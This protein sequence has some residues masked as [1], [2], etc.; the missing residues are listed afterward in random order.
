MSGKSI[1]ILVIGI[2]LGGLG[3]LILTQP[4][5]FR[6]QSW[7]FHTG[8][9]GP[10]SPAVAAVVL[11]LVPPPITL[12]PPR[13]DDEDIASS[14]VPSEPPAE[15]EA[16][17]ELEPPAA[18][19]P[20]AAR[21]R[22]TASPKALPSTT[23]SKAAQRGTSIR[24]HAPAEPLASMTGLVPRFPATSN[25]DVWW[26]ESSLGRPDLTLAVPINGPARHQPDIL[27]EPYLIAIPN[28]G[29]GTGL[30]IPDSALT[31]KAPKVDIWHQSGGFQIDLPLASLA[32]Q[33]PHAQPLRL[34]LAAG[35]HLR[36]GKEQRTAIAKQR[37][38]IQIA[39]FADYDAAKPLT[40]R[41]T[42]GTAAKQAVGGWYRFKP[43]RGDD[44]TAPLTVRLAAGQD[45]KLLMPLIHQASTFSATPA[46][47][48]GTNDGVF[49]IRD[50]QLIAGA[51]GPALTA[52]VRQALGALLKASL[53]Y[54]GAAT[55]FV[56]QGKLS[57]QMGIRLL[58]HDAKKQLYIYDKHGPDAL[59]TIPAL[60][61]VNSPAI[62]AHYSKA[63]AIFSQ[64]VDLLPPL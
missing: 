49:F 19:P 35:V 63:Q 6:V 37:T 58:E 59:I 61:F 13:T 42:P 15:L 45:L 36:R 24:T 33:A 4:R 11:P 12:T 17:A 18:P 57:P 56:A 14:T 21:E 51:W 26:T 38:T 22:P 47:N 30:N 3:S 62:Q 10:R 50:G 5:A 27:W 39:S 64:A 54:R 31:V 53:Q 7:S 2:S 29:K 41:L 48:L 25:R 52:S 1:A 55:A 16:P 8:P 34:E 28:A 60:K 40:L 23:K 20:P 32:A 9:K 44:Q 43:E 46:A